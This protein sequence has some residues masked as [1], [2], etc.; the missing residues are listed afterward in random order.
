MAEKLWPK[1][2]QTRKVR[3]E[4]GIASSASRD[5]EFV[6]HTTHLTLRIGH[7]ILIAEFINRDRQYLVASRIG[8]AIQLFQ[9]RIIID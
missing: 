2:V 8:E 7:Q 3:N 4:S 6:Q 1:P 9:K 5:A